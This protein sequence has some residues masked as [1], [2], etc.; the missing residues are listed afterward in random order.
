MPEM[1]NLRKF[2][3]SLQT[4]QTD[5]TKTLTTLFSKPG[6]HQT[7]AHIRDLR[8]TGA[9]DTLPDWA[10]AE[11]GSLSAGELDHI[12]QWPSLQKESIRQSLVKAID[13]NRNVLFR[14]ELYGGAAEATDIQDS[15]AGD[16]VIMFRSPQSRVKLT[17]TV[18]LG[19]ITTDVG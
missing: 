10:R 11:L 8:T 2:I 16:I 12:N 15:G 18:N 5:T 13:S 9:L 14:W 19:E 3:T 17:S 4:K 6:R 7:H 1:T